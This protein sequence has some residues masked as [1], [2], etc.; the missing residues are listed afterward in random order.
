MRLDTEAGKSIGVP[1]SVDFGKFALAYAAFID[2]FARQIFGWRVPV[3]AAPTSF[4]MRWGKPSMP[5]VG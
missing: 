5:G 1:Q 2:V 4:S 3:R